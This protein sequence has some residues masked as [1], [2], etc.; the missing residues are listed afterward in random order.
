MDLPGVKT[1]GPEAFGRSDKLVNVVLDNVETIPEDCFRGCSA[2]ETA[3]FASATQ[4]GTGGFQDC[5]AL[6]RIILPKCTSVKQNAFFACNS[7]EYADFSSLTKAQ[8]QE[9]RGSTGLGISIVNGTPALRPMRIK[10][11]LASGEVGETQ[12]HD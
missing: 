7:L 12:L 10:C 1:L 6:K 3:S 11:I 9:L 8:V 4:I 2:L 5:S